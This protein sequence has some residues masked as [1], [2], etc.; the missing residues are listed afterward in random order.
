MTQTHRDINTAESAL[1]TDWIYRL[2]QFF[3]VE[4]SACLPKCRIKGSVANCGMSNLPRIPPLPPHITHLFLQSNRIS[5]INSTFLSGLEELQELNLG[6]QLLPLII[7]NDSFSRMRHLR[8]LKLDHN[9]KLHLEPQAFRG[10]SSLKHLHMPSCSLKDSILKDS[11]LEPLISLQTLDMPGNKIKYLQ[12]GLFF[13][14]MTELKHLNLELNNIER[15][16]EYDLAGF[17]GKHFTLLKLNSANLYEMSSSSFD[18]QKCGNPFRGM[19]FETLDLSKVG[20]F[21]ST[22]TL[23]KFLRA[24]EGTKISHLKLAS[25]VRG[26][27]PFSNALDLDR[28]TFEGLNNSSL[29]AL[30]LSDNR[31]STLN[32]G[33]FSP[34]KEVKIIDVSQSKVKKIERNAFEGLQG[35]LKMLNLSHNLL[36]EVFIYTFDS[37]VNLEVLDL[38]YNHIGILAFRSFSG[39]PN[40]RL[41]NLT[42]N[43]LRELGFPAPLPR[44]DYLMLNDN[45]LNPSAVN[46]I[47]Q[48]ARNIMHLDIQGNRLTDL[49]GI[50]TLMTELKHLKH[51]FFGGNIITRCTFSQRVHKNNVTILD[52]HSSSL[53]SVWGQGRCHYLFD[54]FGHVNRL[55]L[56]F[57]WL[58][59]LPE[60][61]FKGLSSVVEMDLSYNTLTY[62]QPDVF[63]KSLKK[64]NL[65][66]NFIASPDPTTFSSLHFLDLAMNR[67]LCNADLKNFLTWMKNTNM[68]F[69]SPVRGLRCEFPTSFYGVSLLEYSAMVTQ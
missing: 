62:L 15:I 42:G 34:L 65:S 2:D 5:E 22:I 7:R 51:L 68:T 38:S 32:Q 16:C 36:G 41:L 12:P 18:W 39:L 31:I 20:A 56:S 47:T 33:V 3:W 59:S 27:L 4:V 50:Y 57:N 35:S 6:H 48:F 53:Q 37:L 19:S 17:K 67:F 49:G 8:T 14:N 21:I 26:G 40:L 61:I 1:R 52:L 58:R 9:G 24:T 28:S 66:N 29:L 60:G 44:L 43:A 23:K 64:L 13:A 30:D 10:L 54:S 11:Y 45:M 25:L 55:N 46:S 69:L 63:P